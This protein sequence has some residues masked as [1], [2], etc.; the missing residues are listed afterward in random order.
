MKNNL[1]LL[2]FFALTV[3]VSAQSLP[4]RKETLEV[5]KKVN[6]YFMKKY[7][8]YTIPSFYGRVRPS[9]IWT[10]G[11]YYEGLMSLHSI[12]PREDYYE[13]AYDW[14]AFHKWGMRNGNTTRNADDHCCG[15]TY[16]DLYNICP[17]P[18]MI[19][20]IKL[21]IDMMVNTPQVN[22][23][24]W[25]DAVQM[26]MPIFAK[27][28]K[29]T[30]EQKYYDKMWDMY[31]YTRSQHDET[32][33]FNQKDG[34]WW[35]DQ[36]FNPPYKEP[37]GEDCYWSRGNGWVYAAL[38][39]VLNEIPSD[40]LHRQD[41]INDFLTMSKALKKC[42]REDGF[43]NVSLHVG[44]AL[45]FIELTMNQRAIEE[46]LKKRNNLL[47]MMSEEDAL[48]GLYNRRGFFENAMLCLEQGKGQYIFCIYADLNN[49]KQINDQFGHKEGD[50]AI[51]KV[52]EYLQ[53]GLRDTDIVGR[54]GGDE[55]AALAV[56]PSEDMG[57]RLEQRIKGIE[58]RFNDAS[59]K[60]YYVE[61]SI[62]YATFRWRE[63][64][65]IQDMLSQADKML[66]ENK[67][68]KRKNV[69]RQLK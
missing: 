19:K 12:Y 50:F 68:N 22:D 11:V 32:G 9:N 52:A 13:Y 24:W 65:S 45:Q 43:W 7:A 55:F 56:I 58:K 49:L 20:N 47:N 27:F 14:A 16:I 54:I 69:R 53:G 1:V 21:S 30:G 33:M 41:Y 48:T 64:M 61:T 51:R 25:I 2:F 62:G 3:S 40:E 18:E 5:M 6:G 26:A 31:Y 23:W 15:Q 44:S 60:D 37:N 63:K 67:K 39:R 34:L 59:D 4:D 17:Q 28:G 8:D 57:E 38:V 29:M 42:Q 66:Y 35:R 46:Q 36:D 10:R